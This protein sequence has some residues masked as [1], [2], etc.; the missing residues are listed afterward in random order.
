MVEQAKIETERMQKCA[1]TDLITAGVE[2]RCR[3]RPRLSR[4]TRRS[5]G[6]GGRV[7][8]SRSVPGW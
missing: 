6:N 7:S 8:T 5:I 1:L 3:V 2:S 4:I